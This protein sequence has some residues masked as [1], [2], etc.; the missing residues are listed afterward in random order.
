MEATDTAGPIHI[1]VLRGAPFL[2]APSQTL[3]HFQKLLPSFFYFI[4]RGGTQRE[5]ES[6]KPSPCIYMYI[7]NGLEKNLHFNKE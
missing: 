3:S 1:L 2:L 6:H 4:P 5:C 7:Q